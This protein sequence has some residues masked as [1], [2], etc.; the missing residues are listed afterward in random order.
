MT[1]LTN[2]RI[3]SRRAIAKVN[4]SLMFAASQYEWNIEFS[5]NPFVDDVAFAY[6]YIKVT[7]TLDFED[8]QPL[9]GT[10]EFCFVF[11]Q[12]ILMYTGIAIN[13]SSAMFQHALYYAQSD[14]LLHCLRISMLVKIYDYFGKF[15]RT[16]PYR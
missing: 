6:L 11:F 14:I 8:V 13:K 1:V 2:V 10:A 15:V 3:H 4:V 12:E 7:N 5:K 9:Q 16:E